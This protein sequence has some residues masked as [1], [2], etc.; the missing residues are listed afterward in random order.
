MKEITENYKIINLERLSEI[1][2]YA[3]N[4]SPRPGGGSAV[5]DLVCEVCRRALQKGRLAPHADILSYT[6]VIQEKS[7]RLFHFDDTY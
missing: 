4:I 3:N 6:R 2:K 7:E 1:W 5:S